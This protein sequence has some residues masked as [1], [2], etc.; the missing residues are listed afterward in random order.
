[1]L[2]E[3][4]KKII[5]KGKVV[6]RNSFLGY[7]PYTLFRTLPEWDGHILIYI[8]KEE[9][10][11]LIGNHI[12]GGEVGIVIRWRSHFKRILLLIIL[13]VLSRTACDKRTHGHD[14]EYTL[15]LIHI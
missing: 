9:E 6:T 11:I 12:G 1:M 2:S 3:C 10:A 8:I 4:S 14:G 5:S 13:F 7:Y 15:S